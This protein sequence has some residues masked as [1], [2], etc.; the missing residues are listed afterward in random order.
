MLGKFSFDARFP[1]DYAVCIYVL[2]QKWPVGLP[3]FVFDV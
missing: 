2:Q 3:Q 1:A